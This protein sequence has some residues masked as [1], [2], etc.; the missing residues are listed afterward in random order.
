MKKRDDKN[1]I[2]ESFNDFLNMW[3]LES[4]TCIS[5]NH[6][7]GILSDDYVDENAEKLIKVA[8]KIIELNQ[9]I[10]FSNFSADKRI[11]RDCL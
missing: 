8:D 1:E 7:M 9:A 2:P 10:S 4:I 5:L 11:F 6:R 3:S